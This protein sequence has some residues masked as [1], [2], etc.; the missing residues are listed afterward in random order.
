MNWMKM[1]YQIGCHLTFKFF[2]LHLHQRTLHFHKLISFHFPFK[3][4]NVFV[5]YLL[6]MFLPFL[7]PRMNVESLLFIK[8][9]MEYQSFRNF[10]VLRLSYLGFGMH[11][12]LAE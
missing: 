7:F 10:E 6:F 9:V 5:F 12:S 11:C 8:S 2:I 1:N 4:F 3:F